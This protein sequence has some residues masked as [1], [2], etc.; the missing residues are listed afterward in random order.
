MADNESDEFPQYHQTCPYIPHTICCC[1][2]LLKGFEP[3][4]ALY[5]HMADIQ[6]WYLARMSPILYHVAY[7]VKMC[8]FFL[9]FFCYNYALYDAS[10]IHI[11]GGYACPNARVT[12]LGVR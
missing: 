6:L 11:T 2:A 8:G 12:R 1:E 10:I 5:L 7:V 3:M 4:T 9:F